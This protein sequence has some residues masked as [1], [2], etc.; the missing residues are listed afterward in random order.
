[1]SDS[2]LAGKPQLACDDTSHASKTSPRGLVPGSARHRPS[3]ARSSRSSRSASSFLRR[4]ASATRGPAFTVA[5]TAHESKEIHEWRI[6]D[7]GELIADMT[8][9]EKVKAPKSKTALSEVR[10]YWSKPGVYRVVIG[11]GVGG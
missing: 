4:A 7:T 8:I 6:L 9:E 11:K 5:L 2:Q 1:M 3:R 10:F